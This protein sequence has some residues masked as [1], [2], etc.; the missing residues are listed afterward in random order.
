MRLLLLFA[1][2]TLLP[3]PSAIGQGDR[4]KSAIKWPS[5]PSGLSAAVRY[6]AGPGEV[7]LAYVN[8]TT[9]SPEH[10]KRSQRAEKLVLG[11][12]EDTT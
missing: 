12:C 3:T 5:F 11:A 4:R 1:L 7:R 9:T 6:F 2:A 10:G 8:R